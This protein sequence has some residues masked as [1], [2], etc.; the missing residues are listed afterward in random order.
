[1]PSGKLLNLSEKAKIDAYIDCGKSYAWIAT[2]LGRSKSAVVGY[3]TGYR[4]HGQKKSSGRP[5]KLSKRD[6]RQI[7]R[8]ASNSTKSTARIK[9]EL[10]LNVSRETVRRAIHR[11]PNLI[12]AKMKKVPKLK[13][14]HKQRRLEFGQQNMNTN[15][16]RV[17][18]LVTIFLKSPL[19]R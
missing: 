1:M 11:N 16:D 8:A 12:R 4:N 6:E 19:C 14:V 2:K 15:W 7:S 17:N 9:R 13:P 18:F 3:A 5:R 10:N